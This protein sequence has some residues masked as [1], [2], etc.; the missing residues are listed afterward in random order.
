M[1][2]TKAPLSKS[3]VPLARFGTTLSSARARAGSSLS[4][5]A[6]ASRRRYLPD[7]LASI[8][9]GERSLSDDDVSELSSIYRLDARQFCA[10]NPF[11]L[12]LD[13]ST[14]WDVAGEA[15]DGA[16]SIDAAIQS[17]IEIVAAMG[18]AMPV[19]SFKL[20]ALG[21]GFGISVDSA[22][23]LLVEQ[24]ESLKQPRSFNS[25]L[26]DRLV[27]PEAGILVANA[28][29]GALVL[30][31]ARCKTTSQNATAPACCTLGELGA[32]L[33]A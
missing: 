12:H 31:R 11:V 33:R 5:L 13:G 3:I 4:G 6:R 27:V 25:G 8:E 32:Y 21:K 24:S 30:A 19:E 14:S 1:E 7:D 28:P 22:S 20:E 18:F 17:L 9:R 16:H 2:S 26:G 29:N 15:N 10:G 23:E